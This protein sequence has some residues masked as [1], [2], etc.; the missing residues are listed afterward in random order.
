MNQKSNISQPQ[1]I[2]AGFHDDEIDLFD[3]WDDLVSNKRWLIIGLVSCILLAAAYLYT[4]KPVYEV[5]SVLKP[6]SERDLVEINVPQLSGIYS[7]GVDEAFEHAK[8]AMLA[9][10]YHRD[11]YQQNLVKI[12]ATGGLYNSEL[13]EAQNFTDFGD[14]LNI[15]LSGNK[16][17]ETFIKLKFELHEAQAAANFLN[18]Y[19]EFSL[20]RRLSEIRQTLESK[21]LVRLNKLEYDASL[22]RDKYYSQKIQRK[23]QLNEAHLIAKSVGQLEPIYSKSD[24]LGSFTPPLYMYGAKALAAEERALSGREAMTAGLP[25]GEEHFITGLSSILFEIRQLKSLNVDYS[26]IKIVQLDEPASVPVNPAKPKKLLVMV[27]SVVAG[28]FLGLMMALM[29]A[30]YKRHIKRT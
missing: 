24:I 6:A 16:D 13:T 9:K 4:A 1:T 18:D 19:V 28:G 17:A 8:R 2:E 23:L 22:I 26:K 25:H 5:I 20:Q 14:R 11:F 12:K 15:T 3:L 29:A 30:A 10:E 7:L 27:L 21:R